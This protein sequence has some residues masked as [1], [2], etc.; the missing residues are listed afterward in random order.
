MKRINYNIKQFFGLFSIIATLTLTSCN[1]DVD[2]WDSETL[3]YS[4][5]FFWELYNEDM[6]TKYYS[7]DHDRQLLI[8]NTAENMEGKVWID[9]THHDIPLKSKFTFSGDSE[10]FMSTTSDF[11]SLD[12][13]VLATEVPSTAPTAAGQEIVEPRDYIRSTV[14]EGKILPN[15]ATTTSGNPVDSIYIKIKLLSGTVKFT[16]Y[17][18]PEALRANPEIPEY[19]WEYDSA[20]YDPSNTADETLIISGHRKTGF[21]EDDH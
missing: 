21:A 9:D 18:V 11:D 10:S 16:S 13:N 2:V 1:E 12:N 5:T 4:G 7:Y 14:L 19:A 20:T 3:E 17:E 15:A 6:S 8:Y